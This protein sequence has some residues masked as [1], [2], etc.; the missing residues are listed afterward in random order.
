MRILAIRGRNIAS[1]AE[2]FSIDFTAEP[3]RSAGLFAITG[4]TGAGKSSILDAMCLALYGH[5]PRLGTGSGAEDVPDPSGDALKSSDPRSC[6]RRGAAEGFAEVDFLGVDGIAYRARWTARRA[7]GRGTGRLQSVDRQ[8]ARIDDGQV[9]ARSIRE[10]DEAVERASGLTYEEFRRTV[11]LAQG[12]FDAF[13]RADTAARADVLE[14]V[15]GTGIYREM[16]RRVFERTAEADRIVHDLEVRRGSVAVKTE[17]ERAALVAERSDL[18]AAVA[19]EAGRRREVA[20]AIG[21]WD[22]IAAAE[23]AAAEAEA[24]LAQA[25]AA[26]ASLAETRGRVALHDRADPLRPLHAREAEAR[27]ATAR[28]EAAAETARLQAEGAEAALAA[29][30]EVEANA[31]AGHDAEEARFKSFGPVWSHAERLD[32]GVATA[33]AEVESAQRRHEDAATG[34]AALAGTARELATRLAEAQ[35][36]ETAAA[37]E[38]ARLAP[39][40]PLAERWDEIDGML[41][42]RQSFHAERA[43]A[44]TKAADHEATAAAAS[45]RLSEIDAADRADVSRRDELD[46]ELGQARTALDARDEAGT[47]HRMSALGTLRDHLA[48]VARAAEA[49]D[50]AAVDREAAARREAAASEARAR[51]DADRTAATDAARLAEARIEALGAPLARARDAASEQAAALRL[52]LV[53]GE[54]CPVCGS[55][56][57]PLHADG[58]LAKLA[59]DLAADVEAAHVR[60]R[61]ANEALKEAQQRHAGA[62]AAASSAGEEARRAAAQ[63]DEETLRYRKALEAARPLATDL[64]LPLGLADRP[65]GQALLARE[66]EAAAGRALEEA[67]ATF[68]AIGAERAALD[69][70]VAER[71]AAQQRI[72]ARGA[73]RGR[74]ERE[75]AGAREAQALA[76]QTVETLGERL[77][78]SGRELHPL[79]APGG[80]TLEELDACDARAAAARDV[81]AA[82]APA[83]RAAETATGHAAAMLADLRPRE[84]EARAQLAAAAGSLRETADL[85]AARLSARDAIVAERSRLLGGEPTESHRSRVNAARIAAGKAMDVAAEALR[86]ADAGAA[87][88]R[89]AMLERARA[90]EDAR[91]A[92]ALAAEALARATQDAGFAAQERDA[93]LAVPTHEVGGWRAALHAADEAVQTATLLCRTRVADRDAQ[94]AA[95]MPEESRDALVAQREEIDA[96]LGERQGRLGAIRNALETDDTLRATVADLE[97]EIA[98]AKEKAGV[99]RAVNAAIGSRNGDRFARFA[100]GVTLDMLV[101]LANERLAELKP[102][103]RL[104][105]AGDL[106]LHVIDA[107]MADEVRSTRSLSGGE[108]FLVSLAL[109]L[110]LAGLGGR[111]SLA[112]TLFIDEGFGSLDADSLEVAID[113]LEALQSQGRTVGV[114]SHVEAMKDRIPVQ[115]RVT[116]HGAGRS[117]VAVTA[118]EGWAA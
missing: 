38:R 9:I 117:A 77:E 116:R 107:D 30:K 80:V 22:A 74:L 14:K 55:T 68:A 67:R 97:S 43:A 88:A 27:A 18:D 49:F 85:L 87:A 62:E 118:P 113:A 101:E 45:R 86:R 65:G 100:Q 79:I 115:V 5:C 47:H 41:R 102:R 57:H 63:A 17:E 19:A 12:D 83:F 46:G 94:M 75:T 28:A 96:R 89:A 33:T 39:L 8:V 93:L 60:L 81:L 4:E 31:R 3:L 104:A 106:A 40:R 24:A 59:A 110:A 76:R 103:Y 64:G 6:L 26:A 48:G 84:A 44:L 29:A 72:E 50:R 42:K 2:T 112:G 13:L 61:G 91:E 34:H 32:S 98:A 1:L 25:T 114:I 90:A 11:L 10:A 16:S 66:A 20:D 78:S 108:R 7:H 52:R 15:T 71:Q 82:A 99:W 69:A 56:E 109:A 51:A 111:R 73:E 36:A 37:A 21:R 53:P 54:A 70:L 23:R 95:G 35:A 105:R 58:A 92:Q